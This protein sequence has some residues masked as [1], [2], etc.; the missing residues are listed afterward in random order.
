MHILVPIK[1]GTVEDV[2][3]EEFTFESESQRLAGILEVLH[4]AHVTS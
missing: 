2:S 4:L 3:P 1:R